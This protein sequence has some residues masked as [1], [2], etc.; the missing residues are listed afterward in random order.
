MIRLREWDYM[1]GEF[2]YGQRLGVGDIFQD[3]NLSEYQ[4]LKAAWK[5]LYG[6]SLRLMLPF[7]RARRVKRMLDGIKYWADVESKTL[8]FEPDDDAKK[9]GIALLSEEVGTLGTVKALAEKFKCDPDVILGWQW[10]MTPHSELKKFSTFFMSK[11]SCR[12]CLVLPTFS[13]KSCL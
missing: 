9:A 13:L 4:R 11:L 8:N 2:S 1:N 6:W 7:M 3:E 5:E 10:G 12:V